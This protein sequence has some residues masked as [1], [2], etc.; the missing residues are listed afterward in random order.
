M[1]CHLVFSDVEKGRSVANL[2]EVG[3]FVLLFELEKRHF[4]EVAMLLHLMGH[5]S[6]DNSRCLAPTAVLPKHLN[7]AMLKGCVLDDF[8]LEIVRTDNFRKNLRLK[9]LLL[10]GVRERIAILGGAIEEL[11][12]LLFELAW[13]M[14]HRHEHHISRERVVHVFLHC[15]RAVYCLR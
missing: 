9:A 14:V 15:T 10:I 7:D 5:S 8:S 1:A 12:D 4:L 13:L 11:L 3:D 6:H 2:A